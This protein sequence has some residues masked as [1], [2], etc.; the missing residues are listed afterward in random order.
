MQQ[1]IDK[2]NSLIRPA[3]R[4]FAVA[5]AAFVAAQAAG[6]GVDE[7]RQAVMLAARQATI[8]LHHFADFALTNPAPRWC[9]RTL[10]QC[11]RRSSRI[12]SY[13]ASLRHLGLSA[14]N[15]FK[16]LKL[17]VPEIERL[18]VTGFMMR[19]PERL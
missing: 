14:S 13:C 5:D 7:A 12:C 17:R 18:V 10:R 2:F 19:C 6:T 9:L 3:L 1:I 16:P 8:E 15:R 11:A 4:N